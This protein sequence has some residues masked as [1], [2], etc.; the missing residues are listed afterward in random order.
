M[1]SLEGIVSLPSF[2]AQ[3][4]TLAALR[5]VTFT[6][7][8]KSSVPMVPEFRRIIRLPVGTPHP[9]LSRVLSTPRLGYSAGAVEIREDRS[10]EDEEMPEALEKEHRNF[11]TVAIHWSPAEF[12]EEALRIGN[13]SQAANFLPSELARA[14]E[15]T[16]TSSDHC[17]AQWRTAELR[18]WV[19]LA[20]ELKPL[21]LELKESLGERRASVLANKRLLLLRELLRLA[22]HPDV[23][24][25]DDLTGWR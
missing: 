5:A 13:P 12:V 8:P 11:V 16:S 22:E 18:K 7:G 1:K 19:L 6:Q 14:V 20:E 21:E 3:E 4:A 17:V 10:S 2:D 23:E 9:A 25:V 24:L 15:W